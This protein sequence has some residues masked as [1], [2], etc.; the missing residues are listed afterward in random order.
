MQKG[1]FLMIRK[2]FAGFA[3]SALALAVSAQAFAGTVT[4][5]GADIMIKTKGGLEV[6]T[7]DKKFEFKIGGRL[8][9][10]AN[11]FD[12]FLTQNGNRADETFFR[13]ARLEISGVAFT[14]WEYTFNRNFADEGVDDDWN[15]LS[16][17]YTGFD[18]VTL[19]LGRMDPNF[20]LEESTSS[21]WITAVERSTMYEIASWV[22][23]HESGEGL[24]LE[25]TL[26][27]VFHGQI[28]GYRQDGNEDAD[29]QN[30]TSIVARGVFAP[31]VSS[32]QVLHFGVNFATRKVEEGFRD[33]IRPRL[34]VRGTTEDAANG[35][36][37]VFSD[38]DLDGTDSV[39]GLE[40]AYM[41]GPFS[42]QG[43][44]MTR[45]ADG[46]GVAGGND[47]DNDLE[48]SG[49][50]VQLAY[51]LTGESRGYKLDGGKFDKIKPENKA[52]G[53]WE[54]FYRY[55]SLTVDETANVTGDMIAGVTADSVEP[56]AKVHT[57]G[58]NWYA[59]E[60]V[61]VSANY[62]KVSADDMVNANGDDDGDA[63]ALRAQ[64]VF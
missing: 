7:T 9:A 64:Y 58:V 47:N 41:Q 40:A 44:Y 56:S 1:N 20:G 27:D 46:A 61:K 52:L 35:F 12:G 45:Q 14:D 38:M 50:N 4:T 2:H 43:E 53:A 3:A 39:W 22:N 42:I 48:A 10:D 26:G 29:G 31:I 25:T 49:Y 13:R 5:D 59:N 33:R 34:S 36:R 54:V 23:D 32:D 15:E 24:R 6:A 19:K 21:K 57:V 60:A 11:S 51:T 18:P 63:I 37:S 17:A 16:L 62:I 8:Q 28:G 30:N 55:D